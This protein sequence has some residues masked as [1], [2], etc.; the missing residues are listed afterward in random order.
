MV[1]L[2]LFFGCKHS[3]SA[4]DYVLSALVIIAILFG[5]RIICY[6]ISRLLKNNRHSHGDRNLN[7]TGLEMQPAASPAT[8]YAHRI[9][10]RRALPESK[11]LSLAGEGHASFVAQH[12]PS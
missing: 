7:I 2:G 12:V 3:R 1:C 6:A 5:L 4:K 9:C 10:L 11:F 8:G